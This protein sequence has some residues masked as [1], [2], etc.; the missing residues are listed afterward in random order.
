[1]GLLVPKILVLQLTKGLALR[2]LDQ[3]EQTTQVDLHW[4]ARRKPVDLTVPTI[5]VR[6]QMK[7]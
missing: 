2:K 3:R 1:V 5:L 7:E 4:L 6:E